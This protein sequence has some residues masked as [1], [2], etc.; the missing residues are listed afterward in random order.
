ML[1]IALILASCGDGTSSSEAPTPDLIPEPIQTPDN[2]N[3]LM[4]E[5]IADRNLVFSTSDEGVDKSIELWGLDTAWVSEDNIRRGINFIGKDNI[6]LVRISFTPTSALADGLLATEEFNLLTQRLNYADLVSPDIDLT[7]N[8]DPP[9]VDDWFKHDDGST[10]AERWAQLMDITVQHAQDRGHAVISAGIFNEPDYSTHQGSLNDF[11]NITLALNDNPRFDAIRLSGANTLDSDKALSWYE[12]LKNNIQEGNTHQLAGSFNSYANFFQEVVLNGQRAI[13]DELHN[14]MEAMVGVEYGVE[15]GIWWESA[16]LA[17]G[18]FVKASDGQRLAYAEHRPKWSAAS[19]Y[20]APEGKIQAFGGGS[21]R[22]AITTNYRIVVKDRDVFFDG[23][24]PQREYTMTIAGGTGYWSNQPNAERMI[25][26]TWGDDI[27]PV[28]DGRYVLVNKESRDVLGVSNGDQDD[29]ANIQLQNYSGDNSQLWAFEQLPANNGGDF[30]YFK[31]TAVHSGKAVDIFNWSLIDGGTI[32]QWSYSNATNQHWFLKYQGA[33]WFS[34]CSHFN[35]LCLESADTS[36]SADVYQ[37]SASGKNSQLWRLIPE[38]AG[39][40]FV[41][42]SAPTAL[43]VTVQTASILLNWE[44]NVETD[45]AGYTVLRSTSLTGEYE[46]IARNIT[47]THFVD[48]SGTSNIK[49]YYKIMAV[50]KSFNRSDY[51]TIV[52]NSYTDDSALIAHFS[53]DE[54]MDDNTENVNTAAIFGNVSYVMGKEGTAAL[55]LNG[56]DQF[57]Q[58]PATIANY[59]ELT[60]A[61][62][63][64][65]HGGD[66][67]QRIFDFGNDESEYLS[68]TPQS[69]SGEMQFVINAGDSKEVMTTSVLP[70]DTWVHIALVMDS[71]GI[72]IYQDN[73]LMMASSVLALTPMDIKPVA[74]FIGRSQ[75]S[76][77]PLF[78]GKI[79]DLRIY[80][81]GLS[82]IEIQNVYNMN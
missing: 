24:G 57:I 26:I 47:K 2:N 23:H 65:W 76:E 12:F 25:N 81:Y 22:Q 8:A 61:A 33:G 48:H 19:V 13:N 51:S 62:W 40:E 63:V 59:D 10:N 64:Y 44:E 31:V 46:T 27:Q 80:N 15:T 21:E 20:R 67:E 5:P 77:D 74:N 36:A 37:A 58:L 56:N 45:L 1:V 79:D 73:V 6:D 66:I 69:S 16:G 82:D 35:N 11:F 30:S 14:V 72:K 54:S 29:G 32:K 60:I 49:Y 17:R 71:A 18:E 75:H 52:E 68:L 34:I 38:D 3:Y 42:P 41:A 70:T 7:L 43:Q 28:I 78:N 55:S 39:V 4:A 9:T 50:D 53:F